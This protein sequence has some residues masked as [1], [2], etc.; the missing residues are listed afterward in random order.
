MCSSDLAMLGA[1]SYCTYLWHLEWIGRVEY[2]A[3]D[4]WP[5]WVLFPVCLAGSF[6]LGGIATLWVER[7]FLRL[8]DR[9]FPNRGAQ[10]PAGFDRARASRFE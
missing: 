1:W 9:V 5:F 8:R 10:F 6:A 7:P 4:R 2:H 3:G